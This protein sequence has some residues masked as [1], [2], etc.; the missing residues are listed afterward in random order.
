MFTKKNI[1]CINLSR[2]NC[3]GV[4]LTFKLY[5]YKINVETVSRVFSN[6]IFTLAA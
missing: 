1:F 3:I 5:S 2:K 4:K 6:G